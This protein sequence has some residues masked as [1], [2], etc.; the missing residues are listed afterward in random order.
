M[1][2]SN[3][4]GQLALLL[5][6]LKARR[7]EREACRQ[8]R[9]GNCPGIKSTTSKSTCCC[10][11]FYVQFGYGNRGCFCEQ[12]IG[13]MRLPI[14]GAFENISHPSFIRVLVRNHVKAPIT[15]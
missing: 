2:C 4:T 11:H 6:Y 5:S 8:G 3:S 1:H 12:G 7:G 14:E 10:E 15:R 9:Q 13:I